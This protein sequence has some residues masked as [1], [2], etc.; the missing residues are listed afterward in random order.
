MRRTRNT[1]I[2]KK[3]TTKLSAKE[4]LHEDDA[5]SALLGL[6]QICSSTSTDNDSSMEVEE[7]S[8]VCSLF[9]SFFL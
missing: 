1:R 2:N 4:D 6:S 5:I 9:Y 7:R 3:S 8:R